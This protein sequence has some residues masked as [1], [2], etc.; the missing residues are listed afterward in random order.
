MHAIYW[1]AALDSD[2][3]VPRRYRPLFVEHYLNSEHSYIKDLS[4]CHG[5]TG[6]CFTFVDDKVKF[7]RQILVQP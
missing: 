5:I 1:N 3:I 4:C 2:D 6:T 7:I